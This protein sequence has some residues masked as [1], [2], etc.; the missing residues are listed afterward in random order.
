MTS[1]VLWLFKYFGNPKG[2]QGP[3]C[4]K[5]LEICPFNTY[6]GSEV[7]FL[8]F[9]GA[10]GTEYHRERRG[11]NLVILREGTINVSA[12]NCFGDAVALRGGYH[13]DKS[14]HRCTVHVHATPPPA[15]TELLW[16]LTSS[17]LGFDYM[18]WLVS[19]GSFRRHR[20]RFAAWFLA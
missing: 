19:P 16:T 6:N 11:I 4:Q 1:A 9:N 20:S 13:T 7:L 10:Y 15:D 12:V 8:F 18:Q 17:G 3:G 5:P 14:L 2:P